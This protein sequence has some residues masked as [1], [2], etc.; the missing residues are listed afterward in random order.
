MNIR[1][2]KKKLN[3]SAVIIVV[4]SALVIT[5]FLLLFS[6]PS[7]WFKKS[8]HEDARSYATKHCL[9]FYPNSKQGKDVAKQL[10][11]G[12]KEDKI[13]DYSLIPYGDYNYVSYGNDVGY[14]IDKDNNPIKIEEIS[15]YGKRIIAD[16]LRYS[17]K[18]QD[19]D[20][21]YDSNFIEESYIDNLDF[22]DVKYDIE[23]ENLKC[24]FPNYDIDVLVPLKYIQTEIGMNFGYPNELYVKPTYIDPN[25]PVVCLTFDDG[26][27]FWSDYENSSSVSIVNTLYKYDATATFYVVGYAL[28]E[29]EAWTD[30]QVYTFLKQ[31][32]NNG[33]EYGSHTAGHEDLTDLNTSEAI[34][35]VINEPVEMLDDIVGYKTLTYRPPGGMFNNDV[36]NSQTYPAILWNIDSEDWENDDPESIYNKVMSYEFDDGDIILFHEIYDE[37]AKAIEKLVPALINR[38]VQLVTVKDMLEYE[39]IDLSNLHYYYNL[40]PWPY[41]E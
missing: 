35:K 31:S 13:Y 28:N 29:R 24:V 3:K 9:V 1:K 15:D 8:I 33:N 23:N 34:K 20:K 32:I 26:P 22:T 5:G 14:F 38:G 10:C 6:N 21:Y 37:T 12:V 30:Y 41:Y 4:L 36:L 17:V 25:H 7:F 16:Y 19:P 18:K 40:N 2:K 39:G 11:K 27:N